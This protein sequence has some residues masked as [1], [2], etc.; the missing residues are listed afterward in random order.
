MAP[1]CLLLGVY[2]WISGG[3]PA[4]AD[5][6]I[7]KGRITAI[8]QEKL[9]RD[10]QPDE[11]WLGCELIHASRDLIDFYRKRAFRPL[12]VKPGGLHEQGRALPQVFKNTENHG[13]NPED[14]HLSCIRGL[15]DVLEKF[16]DRKTQG[17]ALAPEFLA[18]LDILLT[19][20][21]LVSLSHLAAGRV[22][23][24]T[25]HPQWLAPE[26]KADILA[27][28]ADFDWGEDVQSLYEFFGP[29]CREYRAL[30][31]AGTRLRPVVAL[32]GWPVIPGGPLLQPGD[33]DLRVFLL[34]LRLAQAHG[35]QTAVSRLDFYY[36]RGL[37]ARV[38]QFQLRHGL[39][40]DGLVGH[41][42]RQALNVSAEHRHRTVL[43]NLER[44]RWL[45]C[46]LKE[47]LIVVNTADFSLLGYENQQQKLHLKV[48]VGKKYAKTPVFRKQLQYIVL[49]PY[50]N[51]PRSIAVKEILPKVQA[52][53]DY[54]DE[55]H[56]QV[57]SGWENPTLLEPEDIDWSEVSPDNFRWRF[58]QQPGP[59]NSLGRIKFIFP[60]PFHVYIH[61]T[62][63]KGLFE[64]QER[65][66]SHGCIRVQDPVRLAD[67][68]LQDDP[69]WT[70]ER[71]LEIFGSRKR[72]VIV[73]SVPCLVDLTYRTAWVDEAGRLHFR[74]DIYNRDQ[75]LWK[76]LRQASDTGQNILF[77]VSG[78][79]DD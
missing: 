55:E 35:R 53:S 20:G 65:A 4:A 64:R 70:V 41:Q 67:F 61:D 10:T 42:T 71:I 2:L 25:L 76:A 48:I 19:D 14:Y 45:S 21:F 56:L 52:D 8:I 37:E 69:Q 27:G 44:L 47:R 15:L 46:G 78:R 72:K 17:S 22:S 74:K 79:S 34:R 57:L 7:Q 5:P 43:V 26:K 12:W 39:K 38:K 24:K 30:L 3:Q 13:L 54:L 73:P 59:W 50:W 29:S 58:R 36:D 75:L 60:N 6:G 1:F 49:N 28:L 62:P 63:H 18:Q 32:G 66:L 31:S 16:A 9:D 33:T 11:L 77:Q 68:V 51:V 40:I 23:P